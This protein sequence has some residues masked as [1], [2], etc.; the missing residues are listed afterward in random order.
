MQAGRSVVEE[1]LANTLSKEQT[2]VE[3]PTQRQ[4]VVPEIATIVEENLAEDSAQRIVNMF[5]NAAT[6]KNAGLRLNSALIFRF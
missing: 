2:L 1:K 3:M 6:I 4:Q 5:R